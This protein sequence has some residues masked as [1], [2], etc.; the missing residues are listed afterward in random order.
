MSVELDLVDLASRPCEGLLI[1][2]PVLTDS[3]TKPYD[4]LPVRRETLANPTD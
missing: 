4:E 2:E 1:F 3:A